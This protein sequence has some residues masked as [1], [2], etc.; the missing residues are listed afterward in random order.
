MRHRAPRT[1]AGDLKAAHA[2]LLALWEALRPSPGD[3]VA[4]VVATAFFGLLAAVLAD[5]FGLI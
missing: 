4:L 5:W 1:L 2:A 3:L